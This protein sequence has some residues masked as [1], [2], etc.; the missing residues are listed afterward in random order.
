M[1]PYYTDAR[2]D[3][4]RPQRHQA[5]TDYFL[6]S[7]LPRLGPTLTLLIITLRRHCFYNELT[8]QQEDWC[9]P[10]QRDLAAELGV[11]RRTVQ[12]ELSRP[13]AQLFVRR[14]PQY[15]YDRERNRMIRTVDRYRITMDDPL[16]PED[17]RALVIKVA[18]RLIQE[19][20]KSLE[21]LESRKRQSD[22]Y[23]IKTPHFP[24]LRAQSSARSG[25]VTG[26]SFH[27]RQIDGYGRTRGEGPQLPP[28][29]GRGEGF[30]QGTEPIE[31][32]DLE[33]RIGAA[34][35]HDNET[36]H[37]M[38]LNVNRSLEWTKTALPLESLMARLRQAGVSEEV[39]RSLVESHDPG[40]IAR[41]LDWL[42][43]RQVRDSAA[44]LV[45]AIRRDWA[46]PPRWKEEPSTASNQEVLEAKKLREQ[47]VAAMR[48]RD[49][50]LDLLIGAL[51]E[52][53]RMEM[54]DRAREMALRDWGDNPVALPIILIRAKLRALVEQEIA[55]PPPAPDSL[56]P[57]AATSDLAITTE[58]RAE[59][60]VTWF[61]RIYGIPIRGRGRAR[62]VVQARRI[63]WMVLRGWGLSYARIGRLF[64]CDHTTVRDAIQIALEDPALN[65]ASAACRERFEQT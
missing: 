13:E 51:P 8:K 50:R 37:L 25:G 17:E 5:T 32:P 40:R 60:F 34:S 18:E 45:D 53:R 28:L 14:E 36:S 21:P 22:A 15:R 54:W 59:V 56:L 62:E 20:S 61:E 63:A 49:Q 57:Q 42:P 38:L 41:Q 16:T 35:S 2:N 44:S 43:H 3:I 55:P 29:S 9:F 6:R 31:S 64:G 47:E 11:S 33:V 26:E 30:G 10:H 23:G 24:Q 39:S 19:D 48:E 27:R 1:I 7:W 58:A 65:R 4:I 52:N 12:R 46:P